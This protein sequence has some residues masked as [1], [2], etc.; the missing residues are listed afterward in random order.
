MGKNAVTMIEA[1]AVTKPIFF[2]YFVAVNKRRCSIE[3][4]IQRQHVDARFAEKAEELR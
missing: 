2:K 4:Q 1:E 3:R